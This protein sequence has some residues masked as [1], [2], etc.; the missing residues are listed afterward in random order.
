M[1]IIQYN[2]NSLERWQPDV[3]FLEL[4]SVVTKKVCCILKR[5]TKSGEATYIWRS[6]T[7][8]YSESHTQVSL[9]LSLLYPVTLLTTGCVQ[10]SQRSLVK[11]AYKFPQSCFVKFQINEL[12]GS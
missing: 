6:M 2:F 5:M 3:P 11:D 7:K 12:N 8:S 1:K 9:Y 10:P 4:S